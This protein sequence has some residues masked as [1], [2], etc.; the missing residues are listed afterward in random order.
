MSQLTRSHLQGSV[1][2]EQPPWTAN[3]DRVRGFPSPCTAPCG[4]QELIAI[5]N[6]VLAIDTDRTTPRQLLE[7]VFARTP[8]PPASF[9][10]SSDT[11]AKG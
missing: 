9:L 10:R 6:C 8:V 3:L 4:A 5:P 7:K 2:A 11:S 1:P